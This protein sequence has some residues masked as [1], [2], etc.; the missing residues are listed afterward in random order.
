MRNG[1][2]YRRKCFRV[3]IITGSLNLAPGAERHH[4]M[5]QN[6]TAAGS[7]GIAQPE[8]NVLNYSTDFPELPEVPALP[9][10]KSMGG[11]WSKPPAVRSQVVTQQDA[12]LLSL[13]R[14]ALLITF[15]RK[16]VRWVDTIYLT[17]RRND[18]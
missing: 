13:Y 8:I 4:A 5:S 9:V 1:K 15:D 7:S 11:A 2:N 16:S 12:V 17:V 3:A 14:R 6:G 18:L 10:G